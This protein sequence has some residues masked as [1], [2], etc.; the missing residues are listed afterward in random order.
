MSSDAATSPSRGRADVDNL[1]EP[2]GADAAAEQPTRRRLAAK[3]AED[4]AEPPK[5][6][7]GG[8]SKAKGKKSKAKA[9][10]KK[11]KV[12]VG[13]EK[14]A[15]EAKSKGKKGKAAEMSEKHARWRK[16]ASAPDAVI[17]CK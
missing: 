10:G 14:D 11:V 12:A 2:G 16:V 6:K 4:A 7:G 1:A 13:T 3:V 17:Y 9:K 15:G 5:G 8:K